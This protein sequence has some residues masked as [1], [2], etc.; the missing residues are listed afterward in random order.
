M[1]ET[2]QRALDEFAGYNMSQAE[3]SDLAVA[4]RPYCVTIVADGMHIEQL[5]ILAAHPCDANVKAMELIFGDFSGPK[6]TTLKISVE[7]V[8]RPI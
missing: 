7:P 4:L 3:L 1:N 2:V 5:N 6:P 8:R